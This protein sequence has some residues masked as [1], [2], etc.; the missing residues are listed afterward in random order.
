MQVW[1]SIPII[2]E[3]PL[4]IR[5]SITRVVVAI[6]VFIIIWLLR[7]AIGQTIKRSLDKLAERSDTPL[8]DVMLDSISGVTIY[9]T[10]GIAILLSTSI[11]SFSSSTAEFFHRV[12]FSLLLIGAAKFAYDITTEATRSRQKL[13][14]FTGIDLSRE[15]LPI[16]HVAFKII[17]IVITLM[18]ALQVWDINIVGL[19]AGVGLGGLAISLAAK[20]VLDDVIGFL[21]V[22]TDKPYTLDEYVISP[23]GEGIIEKIGIRATYIRRLDQGLTIVPN[24]TMANDPLTNW[25]RLEQRWF[26]FMIGVTYTTTAEQIEEL[27]RRLREMLKEREAVQ[28]DSVVVLFTEYDD[29][30]LNLLIRCYIDIADWTEAHEERHAVNL[31]IRRLVDELD[32]DIAFP[33]R[34]LYLEQIPAGVAGKINNNGNHHTS[35]SDET[36]DKHSQQ[37]ND[38][39]HEGDNNTEIHSAEDSPED[40]NDSD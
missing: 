14:T 23:H 16:L 32:M 2:N 4:D 40:Y 11:L 22:M 9:V 35:N 21:I 1:E 24:S 36:L 30:S 19:L 5:I 18:I 13:A 17:I 27:A 25:S 8:D 29:S 15:I 31:E 28:S 6:V 26:N 34:T 10:L 33:S 20:E 3:I 39:F 7:H 38:T 37:K 12:G